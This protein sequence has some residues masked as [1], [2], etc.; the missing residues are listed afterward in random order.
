MALP[1]TPEDIAALLHAE[2]SG[3]TA[4]DYDEDSEPAEKRQRRTEMLGPVL[5]ACQQIWFSGS[6]QIGFI[7]EKLGDASRDGESTVIAGSLG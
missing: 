6:E 2:G 1:M 5:A 4:D 3:L 7:A